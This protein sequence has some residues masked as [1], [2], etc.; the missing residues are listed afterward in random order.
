MRVHRR[1]LLIVGLVALL[2]NS[3]V[4]IIL[5]SPGPSLDAAYYF[6]GGVLIV[7]QGW[8]FAEP[9]LWNYLTPPD[10]LPQPAFSYWQPLAAFIA[11]LGMLVAP[12]QF[13]A[14]QVP[15]VL[16]A[17]LLPLFTYLIAMQIDQREDCHRRAL[18]AALVMC[19]GGFYAVNWVIPETFTPFALFGAGSLAFICYGTQS[20]RWWVW[21]LGGICAGLAYLTRSDGLLLLLVLLFFALLQF[22]SKGLVFGTVGVFG[23]LL[24]SGPWFT[25]NLQLYGSVQ[26]PGGLST[27]F[28]LDYND[29][30]RFPPVATSDRFFAAGLAFIL[31]S[32]LEVLGTNLQSVLAVN[33]LIF[34]TPFTL[35]SLIKRWKHPWVLPMLL[36]GLGLLVAMTFVFAYPGQRGGWFHSSAALMPFIVPLAVLGLE[37]ALRWVGR[38]QSGWRL[39]QTWAA[40]SPALVVFSAVLTAF[41]VWRSL[42]AWDNNAEEYR[43]LQSLLDDQGVAA[44]ARIMSNN[45]PAVHY[46]TGRGGV[47]LATGGVGEVLTVAEQY[48]VDYVL[49]PDGLMMLNAIG[50]SEPDPQCFRQM[51]TL[52]PDSS[53]LYQIICR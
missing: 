48:A 16:M 36:Y 1:N 6:N 2:V 44:E 11:A 8:P 40:F 42:Q 33:N 18:I 30:F 34:L 53:I 25:R 39:R 51:A 20:Q 7:E 5:H 32:R 23:F 9:Y 28:L 50:E 46:Y 45:T 10:A 52:G 31:R 17:S 3:L 35:I 29:L 26:P 49:V 14:A 38:N 41:L 43:A 27:I 15:F 13:G 37:D 47:P 21:L 19:F 4:A 22:R 24:V 12:G